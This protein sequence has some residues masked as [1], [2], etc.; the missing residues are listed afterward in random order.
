MTRQAIVPD[1]ETV[2]KAIVPDSET[3][4]KCDW[5][6]MSTV[7][8]AEDLCRENCLGPLPY[9]DMEFAHDLAICI[10]TRNGRQISFCTNAYNQSYTLSFT[11]SH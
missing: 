9:N 3:V 2:G 11:H 7:G 10:Q 6:R 1:S 4:G 5:L 8:K